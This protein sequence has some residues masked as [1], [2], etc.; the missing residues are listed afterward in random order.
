M[1]RADGVQIRRQRIEDEHLE[2]RT[3]SLDEL[4]TAVQ[5]GEITDMKTVA[6]LQ[7]LR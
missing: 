5:L 3:F 2:P 4:R 7:F 1:G 6:A